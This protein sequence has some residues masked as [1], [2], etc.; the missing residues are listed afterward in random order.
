M[1]EL[2]KNENYKPGELFDAIMDK[3]HLRSD[4]S[5]SRA[6]G[7]GAAAICRMRNKQTV[8]T[9]SLLIHAHDIT[10]W[11][12]DELRTLAG[13]PRTQGILLHKMKDE[14]ATV[15]HDTSPCST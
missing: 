13:I 8:I 7:I 15:E 9:A 3:F 11:N 14:P 5:L 10:G 2:L 1:I 12:L 6:L 4:A